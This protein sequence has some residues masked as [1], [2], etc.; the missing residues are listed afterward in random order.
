M[1]VDAREVGRGGRLRT[2][3]QLLLHR[4]RD[5]RALIQLAEDVGQCGGGDVA[6]DA[7]RLE[8]ARDAHTATTLHV[9][10]LARIGARDAGIVQRPVFEEACDRQVNVGRVV[11]AIEQAGA[12]AGNRELAACQQAEAVGIGVSHRT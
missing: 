11:I 7:H 6:S 8:L 1:L 5:E 3:A 2:A 10:R 4:T 9:H 12:A